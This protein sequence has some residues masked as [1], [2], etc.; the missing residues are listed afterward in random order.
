MAF[1]APVAPLPWRSTA[2]TKRAGQ[3]LEDHQRQVARAAIVVVIK[4]EFLLAVDG[5]FGVIQVEH[6]RLGRGGI[7]GDELIDQR[8]S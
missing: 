2:V 5:I 3:A 8:F 4:R 6:Q 1:S 7:A